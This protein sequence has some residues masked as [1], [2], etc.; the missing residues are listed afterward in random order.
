MVLCSLCS[1]LLHWSDTEL[2]FIWTRSTAHGLIVVGL[3]RI[4]ELSL[5]KVSCDVYETSLSVHVLRRQFS[6]HMPVRREKQILL[7]FG[8]VLIQMPI[9]FRR[10]FFPALSPEA[11]DNSVGRLRR[12]GGV[13]GGDQ[14]TIGLQ[15]YRVSSLGSKIATASHFRY[16]FQ[17]DRAHQGVAAS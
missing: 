5:C 7:E 10:D 1:E 2:R 14:K 6:L 9:P 3:T 13:G 11:V 15:R 4:T 12:I 17:G 16:A 8:W